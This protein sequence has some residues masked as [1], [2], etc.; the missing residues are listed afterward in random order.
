MDGSSFEHNGK[1]NRTDESDPPRRSPTN[2]YTTPRDT[3][4]PP[5]GK[6]PEWEDRYRQQGQDSDTRSQCSHRSDQGYNSAGTG[7]EGAGAQHNTGSSIRS[8]GSVGSHDGSADNRGFPFH[9]HVHFGHAMSA[10]H[11]LNGDATHQFPPSMYLA[12]AD[13]PKSDAATVCS[14]SVLED[15]EEES[16]ISADIAHNQHALSVDRHHHSPPLS[17][18]PPPTA[19]TLR[20]SNSD[21]GNRLV[22]FADRSQVA[23]ASVVP[24]HHQRPGL[25]PHPEWLSGTVL[26]GLG[27]SSQ[28]DDD[29]DSSL[30]GA[31]HGRA[32]G[33]GPPLSRSWLLHHGSSPS[34]PGSVKSMESN[35]GSDVVAHVGSDCGGS[36]TDLQSILSQED[37]AMLYPHS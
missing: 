10:S 4:I 18:R 9:G 34:R 7:S 2:D 36:V 23:L 25:A 35:A 37:A 30:H 17:G 5:A 1:V 21:E 22:D 12:S 16:L 32:V 33:M 13:A 27:A 24:Q 11:L 20:R 19:A 6:M 3:G 31:P 8:F 15:I 29:G 14:S 26:G 28:Y